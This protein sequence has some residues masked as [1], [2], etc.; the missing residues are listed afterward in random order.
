MVFSSLADPSAV[1]LGVL[2]GYHLRMTSD[3]AQFK[4]T[5]RKEQKLCLTPL[6]HLQGDNPRGRCKDAH[7]LTGDQLPLYIEF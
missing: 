5:P 1:A 7:Q 3:S 6:Y 2:S 4:L